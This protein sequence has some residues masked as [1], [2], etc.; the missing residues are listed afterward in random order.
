MKRANKTITK[1]YHQE[2]A[3]VDEHT[4]TCLPSP[5]PSLLILYI[6]C[7][8]CFILIIHANFKFP[9]VLAILNHTTRHPL[10]ELSGVKS[11]PPTPRRDAQGDFVLRGKVT[12]FGIC[13]RGPHSARLASPPESPPECPEQARNWWWEHR[14]QTGAPSLWPVGQG[15]SCS[16]R[17]V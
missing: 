14:R 16:F 2:L 15:H 10:Q 13:C 9:A 11:A 4:P 8:N 17:D 12:G 3:T 5:S 1:C 7:I 6:C